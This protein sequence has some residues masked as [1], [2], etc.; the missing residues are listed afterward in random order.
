MATKNENQ[1]KYSRLSKVLENVKINPYR[2][3]KMKEIQIHPA[4]QPGQPD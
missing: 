4:P 1:T 3:K 2:S